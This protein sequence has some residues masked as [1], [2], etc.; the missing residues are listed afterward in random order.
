MCHVIP[1]KHSSTLLARTDS[2]DVVRRKG[3]RT[4]LLGFV[5]PYTYHLYARVSSAA[6]ETDWTA[7]SDVL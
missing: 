7:F 6:R 2:S 5:K 1:A 3:G 4:K